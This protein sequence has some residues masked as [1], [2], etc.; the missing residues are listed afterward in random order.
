MNRRSSVSVVALVTMW[1]SSMVGAADA[2]PMV[3]TW[4]LDP[5]RSVFAGIPA[6]RSQVRIYSGFAPTFSLKMIKRVSA[7]V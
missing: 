3:G 7:E 1:M 5:A 2:D 6:L 4:K